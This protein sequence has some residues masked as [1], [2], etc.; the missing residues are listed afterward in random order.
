MAVSFI[1]G[2]N[3]STDENNRPV[4]SHSQTSSHNVVSS[5]PRRERDFLVVIAQVV[6]NAT[7]MRSR[8]RPYM[9][10]ATVE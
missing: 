10:N 2:G 3:Q 5:T 7:T 8:P 9:L 1:G 6:V 4:A